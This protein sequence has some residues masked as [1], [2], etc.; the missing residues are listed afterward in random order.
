MKFT[1]GIM[2]GAI[3]A[4]GAMMMSSPETKKRVMK[5]GKQLM[6]RMKTTL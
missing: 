2:F 4:T 6:R 3:V 5:K 1:K